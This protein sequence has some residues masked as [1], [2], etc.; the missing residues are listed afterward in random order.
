VT[1]ATA[2]KVCREEGY[3]PSEIS[4]RP[5]MALSLRHAEC[6][7]DHWLGTRD[8]PIDDTDYIAP[9]NLPALVEN[10]GE[11]TTPA[12]RCFRHRRR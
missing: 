11:A 4:E 2:V 5:R 6:L 8:L 1:S 10:L 7:P 12:I 9:A 3:L